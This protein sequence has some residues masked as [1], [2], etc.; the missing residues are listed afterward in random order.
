VKGKRSEDVNQPQSNPLRRKLA[1]ANPTAP[2]P[3]D[4]VLTAFAENALVERE[5]GRVMEH[6]STCAEC[7]EILSLATAAM[8]DVV[9]QQRLHTLPVRPPLRTWLPWLAAAAGVVAVSSAVVIHQKELE[10]RRQSG[11]GPVMMAKVTPPPPPQLQQLQPTSVPA[12]QASIQQQATA[13][14]AKS[15]PKE[16]AAASVMQSQS[17]Q[18][19]TP[20]QQEAFK[21]APSSEAKSLRSMESQYG[22]LPLNTSGLEQ[23][24]G[25]S[26]A[27]APPAPPPLPPPTTAMAQVQDAAAGAPA[28]TVELASG[29]TQVSPQSA[30]DSGSSASAARMKAAPAFHGAAAA[31]APAGGAASGSIAGFS[32]AVARAHWR[33]SDTGQAQRSLGNG[34][35]QPVLPDEKSQMRVVSVFGSDVW[36]GGDNLHLYR[37][38]D[39]GITWHLV[40]LPKK[41]AGARA[42]THIHFQGE[43]AGTVEADN[44]TRWTTVDGGQTWK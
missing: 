33:I 21:K 8:P 32:A 27:Q 17:N 6:L 2:H 44:G 15:Q 41:A 1:R 19:E 10:A 25:L 12:P 42:V 22:N 14:A 9:V 38:Q 24:N 30:A 26:R 31:P 11:G 34:A 13:P 20:T 43:Q 37:S 23:Q 5:R 28:D 4:D 3:D 29:A 36:I 40:Q 7:R 18:V 16:A 39:D 35:W